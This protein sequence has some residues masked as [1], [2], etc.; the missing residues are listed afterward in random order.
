M[1]IVNQITKIIIGV[2]RYYTMDPNLSR[3]LRLYFCLV[4]VGDGLRSLLTAMWKGR[5]SPIYSPERNDSTGSTSGWL[6]GDWLWSLLTAYSFQMRGYSA[7]WWQRHQLFFC[8]NT[9]PENPQ[10]V[11]TI[12][13]KLIDTRITYF[14]PITGIMRD[15]RHEAH[16]AQKQNSFFAS[17]YSFHN[18][19]SM[20]ETFL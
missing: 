6:I 19:F 12:S 4:K 11:S 16:Y 20:R 10:C 9:A 18:A 1:C 14:T 17:T 15:T 13:G 5:G 2:R 3:S 7:G 8:A